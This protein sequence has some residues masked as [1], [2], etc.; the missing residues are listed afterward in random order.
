MLKKKKK[1][2]SGLFRTYQIQAIL[3]TL[4]FV[5]QL[6]AL[7][8]LEIRAEEETVEAAS[9]EVEIVS[10]LYQNKEDC[11]IPPEVYTDERGRELKRLRWE[12][13]SVELSE[14]KQKVVEKQ[15]FQR[16]EGMISIPEKAEFSVVNE[17]DG[18]RGTAVCQ[19]Q[20]TEILK[21]WWSDD[22]SFPLQVHSYDAESYQLG[23]H[24]IPFDGEKPR[25]KGCEE[26]LLNMIGAPLEDYRIL[27]VYWDGD[28]YTDEWGILCRNAVAVGEKKLRDYQVTYGGEAEFLPEI[29]WR[30][31]AVY[32]RTEP[33]AAK[34]EETEKELEKEPEVVRQE[35]KEAPSWRQAVTI[36]RAAVSLLLLLF[37]V[38]IVIALVKKVR[39]WYT[40]QK[41]KR[42]NG[43]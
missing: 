27:D 38:G 37:F 43:G 1:R 20:E 10:K 33:E 22:F 41:E 39:S 30:T 15:L 36:V 17:E 42:R 23:D 13:L 4:L 28:V 40:E 7:C 34:G 32:S 9:Q 14:K 3:W 35:E 26:L 19:L 29:R 11:E 21:E 5:L 25:V 12:I 6:A 18:R 16:A 8:R 2:E 24:Q 31:V